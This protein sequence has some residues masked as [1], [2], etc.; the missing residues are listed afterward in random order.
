VTEHIRIVEVLWEDTIS[1]IGWH[2]KGF[3]E[4]E[5]AT[6]S[7]DLLHSTAGYLLAATKESVTICQSISRDPSI[8]KV[9]EM[10][11]IPRS[12]IKTIVYVDTLRKV[13]LP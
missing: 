12:S 9:G 7:E 4:K 8:N 2:D 5:F 3:T 13:R 10:I 6:D 1:W 11:K